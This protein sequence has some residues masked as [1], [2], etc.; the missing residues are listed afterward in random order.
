[1]P[2]SAEKLK[3]RKELALESTRLSVLAGKPETLAAAKQTGARF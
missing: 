1:M 2:M 3:H